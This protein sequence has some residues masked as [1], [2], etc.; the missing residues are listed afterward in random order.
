MF[1]FGGEITNKHWKIRLGHL[2]IKILQYYF[3]FFS[4]HFI[5]SEQLEYTY[6]Y[7]TRVLETKVLTPLYLIWSYSHSN[8]EYLTVRW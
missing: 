1:Q 4:S 7:S 3:L 2:R 6:M 5:Q 8:P